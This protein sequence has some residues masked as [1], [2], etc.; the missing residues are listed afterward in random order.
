MVVSLELFLTLLGARL[1]P[2]HNSVSP[3]SCHVSLMLHA[4]SSVGLRSVK[5]EDHW[6]RLWYTQ[7]FLIFRIA[8]VHFSKLEFTCLQKKIPVNMKMIGC[9]VGLKF[10]LSIFFFLFRLQTVKASARI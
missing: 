9:G 2:T 4:Y 10:H 3:S 6:H 5:I 1:V 7:G 8:N